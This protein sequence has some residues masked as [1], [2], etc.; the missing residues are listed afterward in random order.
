MLKM[1]GIYY[2]KIIGLINLPRAKIKINKS[3]PFAEQ[4]YLNF[5]Q[6]HRRFKIVKNKT[7]GVAIINTRDFKSP[8]EYIQSIKGKNSAYYFS[9][10][11]EKNGYYYKPFKG[12]EYTSDI[13][14]IHTSI[15][16]RQ[17]KKMDENYLKKDFQYFDDEW[18]QYYGVFYNQQLVAYVWM[19]KLGELNIIS[20]IIGHYDHLKNGI[21]YLLVTMLTKDIILREPVV[22]WVMY[23]TWFGASDGLK[24]YKKRLGFKPYKIK[25]MLG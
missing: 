25:W 18:N 4:I 8:D 19:Y 16:I 7:W 12:S 13:L 23:D 15:G 5:T 14:N 11:A 21:M 6:R 3:C 9:K 17:G 2:K 20:R 10:R 22:K 24:L 1:I